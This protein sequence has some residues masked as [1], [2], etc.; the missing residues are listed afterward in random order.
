MSKQNKLTKKQK[1]IAQEKLLKKHSRY[2][3]TVLALA[4][5]FVISFPFFANAMTSGVLEGEMDKGF[6]EGVKYEKVGQRDLYKFGNNDVYKVVHED[7]T[8][9][10]EVDSKNLIVQKFDITDKDESKLFE[11]YKIKK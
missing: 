1:Q 9:L 3:L 10:V 2:G 4:G 6:K 5:A 7:K 8:Y 11:K